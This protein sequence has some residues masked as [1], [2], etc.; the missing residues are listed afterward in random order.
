MQSGDKAEMTG[1]REPSPVGETREVALRRLK[2]RCWRRGT[3]E[4]DLI[5]G[6]FLDARGAQFSDA[7]LTAFDALI[8]EDDNVLYSWVAG[9]AAPAPEHAPMIEKIRA[10]FGVG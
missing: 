1:W 2:V 8:R 10:H 7:E 3:K 4:M 6:G 9:S 5:L